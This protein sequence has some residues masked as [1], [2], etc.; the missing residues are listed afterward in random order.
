MAN[1]AFEGRQIRLAK[2]QALFRAVN[3][4]VEA[5]A[6]ESGT[7]GQHD[8]VCECASPEC[9]SRIELAIGE[10]EAIRRIPTHFFVL[11]HHVFPE[12]E[13]IVDDRSRY[14]VVEK[15]GAAGE[16]ATAVDARRAAAVS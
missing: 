16:V 7:R 6:N 14:V 9:G 15:M 13:V 3:E 12:V 4:R 11:P 8:F 1:E 10:Y 2:N 5:L